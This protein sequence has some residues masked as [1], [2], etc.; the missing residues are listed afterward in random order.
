MLPP[1][2]FLVLLFE[3]QGP[4]LG[5]VF[6][7]PYRISSKEAGCEVCQVVKKRKDTER[8]T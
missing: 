8:L 2:A 3:A 6:H 5:L 1:G 4:V 7:T